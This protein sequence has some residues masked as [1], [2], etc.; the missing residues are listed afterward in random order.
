MICQANSVL[1]QTLNRKH[2]FIIVMTMIYQNSEKQK[3][4]QYANALSKIIKTLRNSSGQTQ[5]IC[6]QKARKQFGL[7]NDEKYVVTKLRLILVRLGADIDK[8]QIRKIAKKG[9]QV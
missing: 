8:L 2:T 7:S 4:P 5:K 9:P 1:S 6:L 3:S